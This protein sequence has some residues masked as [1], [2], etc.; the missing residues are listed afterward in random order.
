[1]NMNKFQ[2]KHPRAWG[3]IMI[4]PMIL[5]TLIV[6]PLGSLYDTCAH[7]DRA[8]SNFREDLRGCFHSFRSQGYMTMLAWEKVIIALV[9]GRII[10]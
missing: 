2:R 9:K 1:M 3:L 6:Y 10:K 5:I 7:I 4:L 8:A